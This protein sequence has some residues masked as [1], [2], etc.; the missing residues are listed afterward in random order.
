MAKTILKTLLLSF[1]STIS[2]TILGQSPLVGNGKVLIEII[3]YNGLFSPLEQSRWD[4]QANNPCTDTIYHVQ[5]N[6]LRDFLDG[7]ELSVKLP[8]TQTVMTFEA[9]YVRPNTEDD[10]YWYGY[11]SDGSI[12]EIMKMVAPNESNYGVQVTNHLYGGNITLPHTEYSYRIHSLSPHKTIC[13]KYNYRQLLHHQTCD[14]TEIKRQIILYPNPA[15]EALQVKNLKAGDMISIFDAK[16]NLVFAS[17]DLLHSTIDISPWTIGLYFV[18][19]QT[20]A[21]IHT[22]KFCKI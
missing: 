13:V 8:G 15:R 20:G 14:E 11:S 10:Y 5:I 16:G 3:P 17:R 6:R 1:F 18:K 2:F 4:A 22:L 12:F 9:E 21:D 19:V 7:K